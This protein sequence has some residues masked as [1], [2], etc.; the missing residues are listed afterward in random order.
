[1][2]DAAS[3]LGRFVGADALEVALNRCRSATCPDDCHP[4]ALMGLI[5]AGEE[6]VEARAPGWQP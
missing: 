6:G 5:E 4:S 3:A 1:M 2:F